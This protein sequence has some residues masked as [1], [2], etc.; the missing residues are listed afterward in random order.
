MRY[1]QEWLYYYKFDVEQ[2]ESQESKMAH[3]EELVAYIRKR[4]K[5][6]KS[7]HKPV[8]GTY[9]HV[10]SDWQIGKAEGGRGTADTVARYKDCLDQTV[11]NIKALRR[12]GVQIDSLAIMSVGDLVEGCG[13]HYDMQQFSVDADRRSQNRIVRELITE[14]ILTLAPMF[15]HT[16]IAVIAGNHGENRKEGKAYTTFADN[17]D[18]GS[19]EAVKDRLGRLGFPDLVHSPRRAFRV[20][21]P[22]RR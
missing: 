19:P 17:D 6:S 15:S 12:L 4:A 1:D 5:L 16:T 11:A 21:R 14:T 18:V 8:G 3:V 22:K 10:L 13:D 2:G 7:S 20:H 9:V